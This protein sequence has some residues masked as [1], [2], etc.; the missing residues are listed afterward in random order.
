VNLVA[1]GARA[2]PARSALAAGLRLN[3][4]VSK[5][6]PHDDRARCGWAIIAAPSRWL[7]LLGFALLLI[8]A[9]VHGH[10]AAEEAGA[11]SAAQPAPSDPAVE[12]PAEALPAVNRALRA[13]EALQ[14]ELG[15]I[16]ADSARPTTTID[17]LNQRRRE[18]EDLRSQALAAQ[19]ELRT[20]LA[21]RQQQLARLGPDR[22]AEDPAIAGERARLNAA[23]RRLE[24]ARAQLNLVGLEADQLIARIGARQRDEF[25][26][27]L[28]QPSRSLLDPRMWFD[29]FA[30]TP[31]FVSRL[32][33]QLNAWWTSRSPDRPLSGPASLL[34]IAVLYVAA[35]LVLM[36]LWGK[37]LRRPPSEVEPDQLR[38]LWRAVG[39]VAGSAAVVLS[40][41][42][43]AGVVLA[44]SA[45]AE[46]RFERLLAG[47]GGAFTVTVILVA[48]AAAIAAPRSP[49]WRLVAL[50][51]RRAAH[52]FHFAAAASLI[53]AINM[54]VQSISQASYVPIEFTIGRSA[55]I[56]VL[57]IVTIAGLLVAT[58][59]PAEDDAPAEPDR[60]TLFSWTRYL[61]QVIWL[62]LLV[63]AAALVFGHIALAHHLM[64][65]LVPTAAVVAGLVLL[66]HLADKAV[67]SGLVRQSAAGRL[68]RSTFALGERSISRL[69]LAIS[70][71]A[72]VGIVLIGVPLILGLWAVTWIDLR[73]FGATIFY[74]FQVGD[75]IIDPASITLAVAV[76]VVGL[77]AAR[78]FTFWLDRRV[79]ARTQ[80][81]PGVRDS[82]RTGTNYAA[83]FIAALVAI[84][85]AGVQF[86]HIAIVAGAL[87]IGIGFGL[88]SIVNNFV[89]GLILLVERPIKVGDW[90]K[91]QGGEGTVKRI[92]VRST[93]IETFD[94]CSIIVPNSSLISESVSN[95]TH[96]DLM[97]RVR[98]PV[99]VSY[100]SDPEMVRELLLQCARDHPRVVAFPQ[101]F[102]LFMDFGASSLDFELRA[103]I[104]DVSYV[105]VIGSEL[106]FA[107]FERF[108][109]AGVQIPF[110]QQDLHVKDIDRL[111]AALRART[112]EPS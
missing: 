70:A 36:R 48:L 99:G 20:P 31:L 7:A 15:A 93:E 14:A 90:I 5:L 80:L 24:A 32:G 92:N 81:N 6:P 86:T 101:P 62:V 54:A 63:S 38:K 83:V 59:P 4:P 78:L 3:S 61:V 77:I 29:G 1:R 72:D 75:I 68:L 8:L 21:E 97:G 50:D 47:L 65:R 111:T 109:K 40:L 18:V 55:T 56:A 73:G 35:G 52:M 67:E 25:V 100:D 95:W 16:A 103:Y 53:L 58:R 49:Q 71:L 106:R 102:V 69:G 96:L 30:A 107:I 34:A 37:W 17:Q 64:T 13:V 51:D 41:Q 66:H 105:A 2:R 43:L 26:G 91:V 44:Q 79:L 45:A 19:D 87:G 23:L 88:Q 27:R 76:L 33:A 108:K 98:V 89:S 9:P 60:V 22:E 104:G 11:A 85:A 39:L 28:L 110:P 112:P 84:S 12:H 94:R 46:P 82:I 42:W 74:G 10:L 57:L